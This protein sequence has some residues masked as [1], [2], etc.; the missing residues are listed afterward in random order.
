MVFFVIIKKVVQKMFTKALFCGINSDIVSSN[1]TLIRNYFF[2]GTLKT[3]NC[4]YT[5]LTGYTFNY[6]S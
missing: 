6:L 4:P 2:A 3:A 1:F 5:Y